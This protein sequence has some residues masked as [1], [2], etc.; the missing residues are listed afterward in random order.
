MRNYPRLSKGWFFNKVK[1][2]VNQAGP[3]Y[4][5]EVNVRLPINRLFFGL[6]RTDE[7]YNE[8]LGYRKEFAKE[9]EE[10]SFKREFKNYNL[11]TNSFDI[12]YKNISA[13]ISFLDSI[14]NVIF[15]NIDFSLLDRLCK[16]TLSELFKID[17]ALSKAVEDDK[18]E[19]AP[20]GSISTV[21]RLKHLNYETR[22]LRNLVF[23][24]GNLPI[25]SFASI[26]N[27][28]TMLLLGPAGIGKTH[29][30]CDIAETRLRNNL[31]TLLVLGQQLTTVRSPWEAIIGQ[32]G[33]NLTSRQFLQRLNRI[34]IRRK[35]RALILIDAI[36]EGDRRGWKRGLATFLKETRKYP[37]L[38]IALTCRI[39]FD[40]VT[41]PKRL[42]ITREY[43]YGFSDHELDALKI[44][45][46]YYKL[47]LPEIPLLTPEFSNP[48]FVKLFCESLE[49]AVVKKQHKQIS[50]I[51]SGQRGMTNIIEDFVIKKSEKIARQFTGCT[52]KMI[53]EFL[54]K[55]VASMM[56]ANKRSWVYLS[57]IKTLI[58]KR[59]QKKSEYR[60]FLRNLISE[61]LLAEDINFDAISKKHFEVV[62][63]PYQKF[64]EHIVARHLF[65]NAYFNKHKVKESLQD[66]GR[67]GWLFKDEEAYIK[68]AGLIE[69]LIVEFP[70]RVNN[71]GELLDY[72][73]KNK[74][75][76]DLAGLFIDSLYWRE[77]KCINKS[78]GIWVGRILQHD[79]LCD[80]MIDALVAL[81]TKPK[82]PY[83][84]YKLNS[85]L[86]SFIMP[87]R[88]L[89]WSE[90]I[91]NQED[92]G[93]IHKLLN[94][95]ES[96][97]QRGITKDYAEM[98]ILILKWVLTST[99]RPIRDRAT[100]C[101]YYL[102]RKHPHLLFEKTLKSLN[103]NDPYVPERMFAASYGVTMA[104][105]CNNEIPNFNR[106]FLN[107]FC[108][109]MFKLVFSKSAKY[110]TTHSLMRDYARHTIEIALLH[111][112]NVITDKNKR[113][114]KP[115]FKFGGIRRWGKSAIRDKDKFKGGS[116][117]FHMDFENY[118]LGRLVPARSNYDDKHKGYKEVKAN[119]L[120]R[121]YKLG[122]SH[123]LF[124][125]IDSHIA[126]FNWNRSEHIKVD[127]Y[128]KKYS[129]IAFYELAG[130]LEDKGVFAKR[131]EKRISDADIDPSFPDKPRSDSLIKSDYLKRSIT[132]EDWIDNGP[133]PNLKPY[134]VMNNL[135]KVR[136]KWVLM[137]GFVLQEDLDTKRDIFVF[138][139]G[140]LVKK[141]TKDSL[142]EALK[143]LE[144][145][146]NNRLP[147]VA[148]DY[149]TFAGEIPWCETFSFY[150]YKEDIVI[151]TGQ[152][153][154]VG[155]PIKMPKRV[156][157][158]K[159]GEKE[160]K[161]PDYSDEVLKRGYIEREEE[162]SLT[163]EVEIPVKNF[164]WSSGTS[165]VNPGHGAYVP[166]KE[167]ALHLELSS[168]PQT[169]DMYDSK[170]K[171]ASLS[172][173]LGDHYHSGQKLMYLRQD[174]LDRYLRD[175]GKALLWIIWGERR[176]KTKDESELRSF[177]AKHPHYK[178]YRTTESYY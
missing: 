38:A 115:P 57:E 143:L 52:P 102:G 133:E 30:L 6:G 34:A 154:I 114:I 148:G 129:W 21:E 95:I 116:S 140:F 144:Y 158:L 76:V 99:N 130:Y 22:Q 67:L 53:W 90:Y 167:I 11:V 19:I 93:A 2:S 96:F 56:A 73:E 31:P 48:L 122:Y 12:V 123:E 43:H 74:V 168:R 97:W 126:Q 68:N 61:S 9:W 110:G 108:R 89:I 141:E 54:K 94:W 46:N 18:K 112:S 86:E 81:A 20:T 14:K 5:P 8:F 161:F 37:G 113:L 111:Y 84:A 156:I 155:E 136:G 40:K 165:F 101:L 139:R 85:Y 3:R 125:D 50:E 87:K 25:S 138:I 82:H 164:G 72:L 98:Y 107:V 119:V 71:A 58:L 145:P 1:S 13:I 27:D 35:R 7:F 160:L 65:S 78:T 75:T 120:W 77:A 159:F 153:A 62:R 163:F 151:P 178:V 173:D 132:V 16:E 177:S 109:E 47:P 10:S 39:P 28:R 41:V 55:D 170:G 17:T 79:S 49:K 29:L 36:N 69:A 134:L 121:I 51:S 83:S 45:T 169:F 91:R 104:L 131:Y 63:F 33:L 59:L 128:G 174:L 44:Y 117:P 152:K 175:K 4:T 106:K 32:L 64:S 149:L 60:K 70:N 15:E 42:N 137:D 166:S 88:D 150:T 171:I 23:R 124:K 26:S 24:L 66:E 146:G 147:E 176:I 80:K 127:R 100:R 105:H 162:K 157:I 118:T 172:F 103:V 142:L 135:C 92:S